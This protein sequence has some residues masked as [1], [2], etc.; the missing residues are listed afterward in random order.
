VRNVLRELG[1][2]AMRET[3]GWVSIYRERPFS[4]LQ[5]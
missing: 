3:A 1:A 2:E 4:L 5:K